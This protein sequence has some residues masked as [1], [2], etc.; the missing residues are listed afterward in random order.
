MSRRNKVDV[1]QIGWDEQIGEDVSISGS[2][3]LHGKVISK[4][5]KDVNEKAISLDGNNDHILVS[6]EDDFSFTNGSSD[7]AFS[8]SAWVYVGDVSSDNGPFM[9][10]F[11]G[12]TGETEYIFK[13]GDGELRFFIYDN[14]SAATGNQIRT[15]AN[16]ATLTD[17]TWHHVVA[18]YSGN[19]SQT[20]MKMYMDGSQVTAT[21]SSLGSYSRVRNTPASFVIGATQDLANA[22]RVFEDRMADC[23]VFSKELSSS[24]VTELYN[25]GKVMNIRNH[26]A[27]ANVISWWKMGDDDDSTGSGGIRDYVS[28][29]HGTLTNGAAII[30]EPGLS[31]DPLDSLKTNASGSLGIGIESPDE[32]LHVYGSTKLEGPLILKERTY[33]PDNPTE[34]S[35][36]IWMS[37]GHGSG[38]DGD[39]M[40][41][42]TAGGVTKTVTLVDFSTS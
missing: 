27:F 1:Q 10:K 20:G 18:T 32:A 40:I 22:N 42:I 24:E 41:K 12:N 37:N 14:T 8:L 29:H 21:Q 4:A 35:S 36:V 7:T 15:Q 33:D 11:N 34:G 9:S 5:E 31:S 26:S 16:S 3:T 38:D 19:G 30:D 2:L 13:H 25:S 39:I 28:G 17:T 23:A 6:D